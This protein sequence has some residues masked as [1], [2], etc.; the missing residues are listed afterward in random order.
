MTKHLHP[1]TLAEIQ[2]E[3]GYPYIMY[4][5][6]V[7]RANPIA[8]R[9]NMLNLCLEILQVNSPNTYH[10]DLTYD[11]VGEDI[12]CNLGSLNIAMAMDSP[13]FAQ[14]VETAIRGLTAVSKWWRKA[15][16]RAAASAAA[17]AK[18]PR[19]SRN[20][21]TGTI[22]SSAFSSANWAFAAMSGVSVRIRPMWFCIVAVPPRSASKAGRAQHNVALVHDALADGS[23]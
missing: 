3:S 2:F 12:S 9:V 15:T 19:C 20:A 7:N 5:D 4:E 23:R 16:A 13:D 22:G 14:T 8:G 21:Q 17:E 1:R 18:R 11:E 10:D 6:V